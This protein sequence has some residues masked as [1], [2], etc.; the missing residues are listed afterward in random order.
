LVHEGLRRRARSSWRTR[1]LR[2]TQVAA[3]AAAE[4]RVRAADAAERILK[5]DARN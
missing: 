4:A 5:T 3:G 2:L 1:S